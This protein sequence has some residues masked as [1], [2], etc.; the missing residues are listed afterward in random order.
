MNQQVQHTEPTASPRLDVITD[1]IVAILKEAGV[2]E[3]YLFGSVARGE[4]RPDSDID[5]LVTFDRPISFFDQQDLSAKLSELCDRK[6]DLLTNIHPV[7]EPYIRPT[8][9]PI[10]L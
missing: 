3:A 2:T 7:F 10:P 4:E 1:E 5:V 8:L 6:V 9:V